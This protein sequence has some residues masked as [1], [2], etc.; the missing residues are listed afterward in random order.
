MI[1][2]VMAPNTSYQRSLGNDSLSALTLSAFS[3]WTDCDCV[4]QMV[5]ATSS[6]SQQPPKTSEN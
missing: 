5:P 6:S 4:D 3:S 2:K 1:R